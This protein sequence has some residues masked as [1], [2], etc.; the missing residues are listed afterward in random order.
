MKKEL[1]NIFIN[2]FRKNADLRKQLIEIIVEFESR[3]DDDNHRNY[4]FYLI[5]EFDKIYNKDGYINTSFIIF[6]ISSHILKND[7][8]INEK[9][10]MNTLVYLFNN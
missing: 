4:Y 10:I 6:D 3:N 9:N 8:I 2:E 7:L 5:D 1:L